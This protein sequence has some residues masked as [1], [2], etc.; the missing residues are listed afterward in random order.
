MSD[1]EFQFEVITPDRVVLQDDTVVSVIVPGSEGHLGVLANHA[2]MM[3]ELAIGKLDFRRSDGKTGKMAICGGF[4]EV[5]ENSVS[6]LAEAAELAED[7]DVE[8]A[9]E[10]KKRA[11]E[12][13]KTAGPDVDRA[14]AEAALQRA[15]N[16]LK[17][18]RQ[19]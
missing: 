17:I 12:R 1:R 19:T 16:R 11:S 15:I 6:V 10:S 8:R 5:F 14:R 4:V 18:A 2:P 7:I 3:A 13:L 9:E